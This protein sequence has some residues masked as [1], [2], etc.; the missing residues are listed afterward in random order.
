LAARFPSHS[1]S[2]R[3]GGLVIVTV[4]HGCGHYTMRIA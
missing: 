1:E 3:L 4:S 2:R